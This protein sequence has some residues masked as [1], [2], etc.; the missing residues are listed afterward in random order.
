MTT[1]TLDK[2]ALHPVGGYCTCFSNPYD[3]CRTCAAVQANIERWD[4]LT[5]EERSKA[6][7]EYDYAYPKSYDTGR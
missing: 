4:A 1:P 5:P 6:Q 2:H 3:T 7:R